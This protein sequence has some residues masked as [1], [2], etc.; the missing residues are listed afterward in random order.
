MFARNALV[1]DDS[2]TA[3]AVLKHQLDQF[4]V[5][6]ESAKDGSHAL[7]LLR[8]HTPDVIFLD[9]VMP[10]LDGFQVLERL[11]ADNST[12]RI[13]VVMYTSQAAPQYIREAK[14][15]GA[16]AV[17]PKNVTDEQ[18]VDALNKAE[19]YQ[20]SAANDSDIE[21]DH[22]VNH[23]NTAAASAER[24]PD[25]T[26]RHGRSAAKTD[27]EQAQTHNGTLHLQRDTQYQRP[28]SISPQELRNPPGSVSNWLL[29]VLLSALL[30]SHIHMFLRDKSQAQLTNDLRQ[31]MT[32]AQLT[33]DL[34]QM[35]AEESARYTAIEQTLSAQQEQL[36]ETSSRQVELIMNLLMDRAGESAD[37]ELPQSE[38]SPPES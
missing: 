15:L 36:N 3:R 8:D 11:K 12:R 6:V 10:G 18:L 13:P 23:R 25:Q 22:S 21:P 4:D 16:V 20:I 30:V 27:R 17:I 29:A 26:S 35:M 28:D 7:K 19:V 34:R 9:H 38:P 1:V 33:N 24:K 5:V 14:I 37:E 2:L 32:E 31:M